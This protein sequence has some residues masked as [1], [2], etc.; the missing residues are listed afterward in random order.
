MAKSYSV[1]SVV[2]IALPLGVVC[3]V[4]LVAS[5]S[6]ILRYYKLSARRQSIEQRIAKGDLRRL[7]ASGAVNPH[8]FHSSGSHSREN[9]L[10]QST[11]HLGCYEDR[12]KPRRK[13]S[14]FEVSSD[15]AI[16]KD[17]LRSIAPLRYLAKGGS[18]SALNVLRSP[19]IEQSVSNKANGHNGEPIMEPNVDVR[20]E[21]RQSNSQGVQQAFSQPSPS[22]S[23]R[24]T[25]FSNHNLRKQS[26]SLNPHAFLIESGLG[27]AAEL[28]SDWDSHPDSRLPSPPVPPYR[29]PARSSRMA[30]RYSKLQNEIRQISSQSTS[31]TADNVPPPSKSVLRSE[32]PISHFSYAYSR[33]LSIGSI[34]PPSLRSMRTDR[35]RTRFLTPNHTEPPGFKAS[36]LLGV[37][38][39]APPK[40]RPRLSV[41]TPTPSTSNI[42]IDKPLESISSDRTSISHGEISSIRSIPIPHDR[43]KDRTLIPVAKQNELSTRSSLGNGSI[44]STDELLRMALYAYE[45]K[46]NAPLD[47]ESI[48]LPKDTNLKP[49]AQ[50]STGASELLT[51]EIDTVSVTT[52]ARET[53]DMNHTHTS[54][55]RAE[56]TSLPHNSDDFRYRI[57]KTLQNDEDIHEGSERVVRAHVDDGNSKHSLRGSVVRSDSTYSR[58]RANSDKRHLSTLPST[59]QDHPTQDLRLSTIFNYDNYLGRIDSSTSQFK[60][61]LAAASEYTQ[62]APLPNPS[63]TDA[64]N[65][66]PQQ[67][68]LVEQETSFRMKPTNSSEQ[69]AS[70]FSLL[71]S[72]ADTRTQDEIIGSKADHN[73]AERENGEPLKGV[74]LQSPR[75][76]TNAASSLLRSLSRV[77][78]SLLAGKQ[79]TTEQRQSSSRATAKQ[80][81]P[82]KPERRSNNHQFSE[83]IRN[84]ASSLQAPI[85]PRSP[86]YQP[87]QQLIIEPVG[88]AKSHC[89]DQ[90]QRKKSIH[91]HSMSNAENSKLRRSQ[92]SGLD[93]LRAKSVGPDRVSNH[94]KKALRVNKPL[95]MTPPVLK[96]GVV[97]NLRGARFVVTVPYKKILSDELNIH[98]NDVV[99]IYEVFDDGWCSV[100][101]AESAIPIAN[102][103]ERGVCPKSCL[104]A[105]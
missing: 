104:A 25:G 37:S 16:S 68:L 67:K 83:S 8:R 42:P 43:M 34:S 101:I 89:I 62:T 33:E 71:N 13:S 86:G 5:V 3:L 26:I 1:R 21:N 97:A 53:K 95:P 65:T 48:P 60:M 81:S 10:T 59:S 99:E 29:S 79:P 32:R 103:F 102:Q 61:W 88:N 92:T 74:K 63:A 84:I 87:G 11:E 20:A 19:A 73:G 77:S 49:P 17:K 18:R 82:L 105:L 6:I 58:S 72:H 75:L 44:D 27:S 47:N 39:T 46:I 41:A 35:S 64:L 36:P 66:I 98:Y 31:G 100:R 78:D 93:N 51:G 90:S 69:R 52:L 80:D 24:E 4:V 50:N 7:S 45:E 76:S 96:S 85:S 57:M 9:R 91:G 54:E 30:D 22:P 70:E 55:S 40:Q 23:I 94:A 56:S 28:V 38:I 14:N 15:L 2:A 12:G